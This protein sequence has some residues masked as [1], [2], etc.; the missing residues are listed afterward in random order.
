M[1]M[2]EFKHYLDIA[3]EQ[4]EKIIEDI[5]YNCNQNDVFFARQLGQLDELKDIRKVINL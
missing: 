1:T 2:K 4:K 5:K 3:I